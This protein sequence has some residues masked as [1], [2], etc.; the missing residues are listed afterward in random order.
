VLVFL[1]NHL[2]LAAA[3]IA[4]IYKERW[5]IELFFRALKQSLRVKTFVGTSANALKTQ[6][7]TALIAMLLVNTCNC[8][9]RSVGPFRIWWHSC[10]SSCLFIVICGHGSTILSNHHRCQKD[11]QSS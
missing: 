7:W 11:R 2:E 10:G 4:A 1:T 9:R 5:Q 8:D 3:T 6:L